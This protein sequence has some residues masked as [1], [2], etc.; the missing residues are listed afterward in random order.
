MY[1][2]HQLIDCILVQIF[3]LP[4]K[5]VL[6]TFPSQYLSTI[7]LIL[8]FRLRRWF[9]FFQ[10]MNVLLCKKKKYI[11]QDFYLLW[12]M[13]ST[14]FYTFF[15]Y[16]LFR[17]LSPIL[18]ESRLISFPAATEMFHFAAFASKFLYIQNY[19]NFSLLILDSIKYKIYY[20]KLKLGSPIRTSPDQSALAAPRSLS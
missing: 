10:T 1:K 5:R 18:T 3:S 12:S 4:T 13:D 6:F 15:F 19:D 9:S 20:Q 17:V 7:D 14:M 2:P 11:I 8:I 16:S